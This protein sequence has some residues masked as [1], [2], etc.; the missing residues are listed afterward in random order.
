MPASARAGPEPSE[1]NFLPPASSLLALSDQPA[2]W[3]ARQAST[4]WLLRTSSQVGQPAVESLA[5]CAASATRPSPPMQ[6]SPTSRPAAMLPGAAMPAST[7]HTPLVSRVTFTPRVSAAAIRRSTSGRTLALT[8]IGLAAK[9]AEAG[10]G[11]SL[12]AGSRSSS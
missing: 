7:M 11:E 2:Y 5:P 8:L 3:L 9:A 1:K 6:I 12:M 10:L 4:G